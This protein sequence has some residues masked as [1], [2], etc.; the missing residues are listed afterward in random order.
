MA[1]HRL[2]GILLPNG[3]GHFGP[4]LP[5][6]E[7]SSIQS[8]GHSSDSLRQR[9]HSPIS[10]RQTPDGT[11]ALQRSTSGTQCQ[12]REARRLS[13]HSYR[14]GCI[15]RRCA[16]QMYPQYMCDAMQSPNRMRGTDPAR[17][18]LASSTSHFC[19]TEPQHAQQRG[20]PTLVPC[21]MPSPRVPPAGPTH[22]QPVVPRPLSQPDPFRS[23]ARPQARILR[24]T[25]G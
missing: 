13:Q 2:V 25:S 16:R 14:S 8:T 19:T 17:S 3:G 6:H 9:H 11:V 21:P 12:D 18:P 4:S 20:R 10:S 15:C 23:T 5:A 7:L 1:V 22:L 24:A